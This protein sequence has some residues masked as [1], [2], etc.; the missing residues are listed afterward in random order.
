M[1][2]LSEHLANTTMIP[3]TS[4]EVDEAVLMV[5]GILGRIV[6]D[7]ADQLTVT[8]AAFIWS[9]ERRILGRFD[10]GP[11][12]AFSLHSAF[13]RILSKDDIVARHF[14]ET[15][16]SEKERSFHISQAD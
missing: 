9:R 7:D 6:R 15:P 3:F 10:L 5:Y 1:T 14:A 11:R 8:P 13:D 2:R 4:D 12:S 16:A